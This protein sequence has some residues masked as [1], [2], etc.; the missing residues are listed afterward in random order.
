MVHGRQDLDKCSFFFFFAANHS[1]QVGVWHCGIF[2]RDIALTWLTMMVT[3]QF[4]AQ[5]GTLLRVKKNAINNYTGRK[6]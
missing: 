4:I 5:T 2:N 3:I 6:E 1:E